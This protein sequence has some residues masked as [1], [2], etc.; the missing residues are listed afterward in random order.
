MVTISLVTSISCL[1]TLAPGVKAADNS[2][3][4]LRSAMMFG[5]R[6]LPTISLARPGGRLTKRR[7]FKLFSSLLI[8]VKISTLIFLK[9]ALGLL[10]NGVLRERN[11]LPECQLPK[12]QNV[13]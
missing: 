12:C 4:I 6:E 7:M 13:T 8:K 11:L 2:M 10:V 5:T 9:I 3:T 1:F